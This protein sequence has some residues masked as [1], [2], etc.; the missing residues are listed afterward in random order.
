M[1]SSFTLPGRIIGGG[2][3]KWGVCISVSYL[4]NGGGCRII[5]GSPLFGQVP[6]S[7]YL[8]QNTQI[9]TITVK[10]ALMMIIIENYTII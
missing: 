6:I 8:I 1:L 2:A 3:N 5:G 4:I 7:Q 10:Y 9:R